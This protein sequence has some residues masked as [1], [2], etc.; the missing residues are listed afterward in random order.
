MSAL[1]SF[2]ECLR[3]GSSDAA[4]RRYGNGRPPQFAVRVATDRDEEMGSDGTIG[5]FKG[6]GRFI[7]LSPVL[8]NEDAAFLLAEQDRRGLHAALGLF[9]RGR[10]KLRGSNRILPHSN[11]GEG[12]LPLAGLAALRLHKCGACAINLRGGSRA[13]RSCFYCNI[14]SL[15]A[16][17]CEQQ[18]RWLQ[19]W[20]Q[21]L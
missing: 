15:G 2:F 7:N 3:C 16:R 19:A 1:L 9:D 11:G 17:R 6:Y 12:H 14:G 10:R 4:S 18:Q 20:S 8:A 21:Q 13:R 5:V